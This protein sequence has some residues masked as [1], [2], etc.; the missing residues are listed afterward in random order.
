M[1]RGLRCPSRPCDSATEPHSGLH[2]SHCLP[3]GHGFAAKRLQRGAIGACGSAASVSRPIQVLSVPLLSVNSPIRL[4]DFAL[5]HASPSQRIACLPNRLAGSRRGYLTRNPGRP[6]AGSL[7]AD[8]GRRS[9]VFKFRRSCSRRCSLSAP[10]SRTPPRSR[11]P[12]RCQS[13]SCAGCVPSTSCA[14][15]VPSTSCACRRPVR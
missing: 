4:S 14:G 2:R 3:F 15:C 10:R 6:R 9:S 1:Y 11:P 12:V 8:H 13:T 5:C 7:R